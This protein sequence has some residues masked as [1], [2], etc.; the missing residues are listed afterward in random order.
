M[1]WTA[2]QIDGAG[3]ARNALVAFV[4]EDDNRGAEIEKVWSGFRQLAHLARDHIEIERQ[5]RGNAS[6]DIIGNSNGDPLFCVVHRT[7]RKNGHH[8]CV[9]TPES[10]GEL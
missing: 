3:R 1:K 6:C 5:A 4:R 8:P 10:E 7:H 9:A 2:A